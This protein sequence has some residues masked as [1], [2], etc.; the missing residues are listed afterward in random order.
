MANI[1]RHSLHSIYRSILALQALVIASLMTALLLGFAPKGAAE[2]STVQMTHGKAIF[3]NRCVGCHTTTEVTS[4][5]PGLK[6]ILKQHRLTQTAVRET[7][8]NGKNMM[9]SFGDR[10]SP[11]DLNDL[12][13][14]L[15]LL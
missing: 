13:A 15:K 4:V 14:Y 9:P 6:G 2:D 3:Q 11:E 5:G 10:L 8:V 7:V 12:L 1:C